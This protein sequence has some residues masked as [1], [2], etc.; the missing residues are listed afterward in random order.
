MLIKD[1]LTCYYRLY[2]TTV[3]GLPYFLRLRVPSSFLLI[4][5]LP[6]SII[7]CVGMDLPTSAPWHTMIVLTYRF[8]VS[9]SLL[10]DDV[11]LKCVRILN[12]KGCTSSVEAR[13]CCIIKYQAGKGRSSW[14]TTN[15]RGITHADVIKSTE[16]Y[17]CCRERLL[18]ERR[19]KRER[20]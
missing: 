4:Q 1:Y 16:C 18:A 3:P 11:I 19:N 7:V 13:A 12:L 5:V 6:Y 2:V 9:S 10:Y 14:N 20:R 17:H 8:A 15:K